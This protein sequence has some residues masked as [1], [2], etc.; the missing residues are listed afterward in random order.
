MD[1]TSELAPPGAEYVADVL[2]RGML[3]VD[4]DVMVRC[5]PALQALGAV[6][7]ERLQAA[8]DDERLEPRKRELLRTCLTLVVNAVAFAGDVRPVVVDALLAVFRVRGKTIQSMAKRAMAWCGAGIVDELIRAAIKNTDSPCVLHAPAGCCRGM[9]S[10][11]FP[12]GVA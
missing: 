1:S 8:I 9:W 3:T 2:I 12:N 10:P 4:L 6:S 5:C 11:A 7:V